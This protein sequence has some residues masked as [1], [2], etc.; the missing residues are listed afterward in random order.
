[1]QPQCCMYNFILW[2][3]AVNQQWL[4]HFWRHYKTFGLQMN[5]SLF[6]WPTGGLNNRQMLLY[7]SRPNQIKQSKTWT[8]LFYLWVN[9]GAA[10]CWVYLT[11][12]DI[13]QTWVV[14]LLVCYR[15]FWSM[16]VGTNW[17]GMTLP[18]K[19][20]STRTMRMDGKVR[21]PIGRMSKWM[22][23]IQRSF[24]DFFFYCV[25]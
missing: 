14:S 8:E 9:I 10:D 1:M 23:I 2:C 20:G 12:N 6:F 16:P 13:M 18:E 4:S 11:P 3:S 21:L 22:T 19:C 7:C 24:L 5:S 17:D 25:I 15:L